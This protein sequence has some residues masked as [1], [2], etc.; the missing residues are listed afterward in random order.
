MHAKQKPISYLCTIMTTAALNKEIM[1]HLSSLGKNQQAKV[2]DYLKS[3]V[4]KNKTSSSQLLS[5]AGAIPAPD[6][7]QMELVINQGC[8]HID[9]HEW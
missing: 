1:K 6:L 8:E 9:E 7:K 2:L 4:R 3:L 5:F